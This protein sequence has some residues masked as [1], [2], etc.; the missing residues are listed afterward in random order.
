MDIKNSKEIIEKAIV[1]YKPKAIV[2][3]LSGG[4]DSTTAYAV[5]KELGIEIDL[6]V[7]G[8]T[9]TGIKETTEFAVRQAEAQGDKI[10]IADAGNAYVDY[11]MR[12]GFFGA[13]E[14]AHNFAYH[15]LKIGHFR[16]AVSEH[17]RKRRRNYPIL[18]L[19]GGRRQESKRRLVTMATPYKE[20][21]SQKN[22]IWVNLINE[23]T[24]DD[25]R[26]YLEGNSIERSPVAKNLCRSGECMCGTMQSEGDR[27]ETAFFYPEWGKWLDDLEK[28]VIKKFPWKWGENINKYHWAEM[29]GQM[30]MFKP[31]C[32]DCTLEI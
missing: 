8:Y 32:Q 22:N 23:F 14:Q 11:V 25:C 1:D 2:M 9:R 24:K 6:V 27:N 26:N 18:F 21:P 17:I 29:N 16:K 31:M 20:D 10:V 12:K 4:D 28:E 3:M 30:N 7:H 15:V 13:G 5:A 19:N